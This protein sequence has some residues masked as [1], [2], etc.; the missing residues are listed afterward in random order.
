MRVLS[1]SREVRTGIAWEKVELP[2]GRLLEV[3]LETRP[4]G[5][6][7]EMEVALETRPLGLG[8]EMGYS[9]AADQWARTGSRHVGA[10]EGAAHQLAAVAES[11][12][13]QGAF[14]CGFIVMVA[15]LYMWDKA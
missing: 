15:R 11:A 14:L 2:T 12:A 6:G 13:F 7:V 8:V 1:S 9:A 4:L 3:A 5:L 10:G